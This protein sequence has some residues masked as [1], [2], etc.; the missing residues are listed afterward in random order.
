MGR[1][2]VDL[3][4]SDGPKR[5]TSFL[6]NQDDDVMIIDPPAAEIRRELRPLLLGTSGNLNTRPIRPSKRAK[7]THEGFQTPRPDQNPQPSVEADA[8]EVD[9]IEVDV[10]EADA[11]EAAAVE[12][13]VLP[14]IE[15]M[16]YFFTLPIEIRDK[17]YRHL[18]VSSKPIH[19]QHLWTEMARRHTRRGRG[20]GQVDPESDTTISPQ[21][22]RV[23][24]QTALEGTR[25]LYS[26]NTFLYQLRDPEIL[27]TKPSGGRRSNRNTRAQRNQATRTINLEKY[28]HLIRNMAIEL[29]PNR[30]GAEY[31]DLMAE[32]LGTLVSAPAGSS[33]PRIPSPSRPPYG[34]IRLHTL[35]ITVSPLFE[36]N[37]R[38]VRAAAAAGDQDVTIR[39]GRFLSVVGFFSRGAPVLKA[40]Q[41]I[42]TNFLRINVHVNSD[43]KDRRSRG[44]SP[45]L[46]P[47]ASD[48][49]EPDSDSDSSTRPKK[50]KHRHLE[51]TLDLRYLPRHM[52]PLQ[53]AEAAGAI[54]GA[55][56]LM[57]MKRRREGEK[58][59]DTLTNLRRHIEQACHTPEDGLR[60]GIWEEHAVAER[61]RREHRAREDARFDADAYDEDESEEEEDRW[62][63]RGMKSLI[64]SFARVGDEMRVYR[65]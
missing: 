26:E 39:N 17:I 11:T 32:A 9:V 12:T 5:T 62:M 53:R 8:V 22:L 55:A 41:R 31:Q 29:E 1:E 54:W 52:E 19:V 63:A 20:R 16:T 47:N 33:S 18:L 49:E 43:V 24:R 7:Q 4:L 57:Q 58:A 51:T 42:N 48:E 36:P 13:E 35:T 23:C 56:R 38:T 46:D 6:G 64:I 15:L 40:L 21:I 59:E 28:G 50:P 34:P 3:T 61:R 27:D 60:R 30:T 44:D 10:V 45:E 14:S 37:R 25:V 65:A 2:V